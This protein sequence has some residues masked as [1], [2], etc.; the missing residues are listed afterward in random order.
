MSVLV[1]I[2]GT[3]ALVNVLIYWLPAMLWIAHHFAG[4]SYVEDIRHARFLPV[5]FFEI[6][7]YVLLVLHGIGFNWYV[8]H[9][10]C[11]YDYTTPARNRWKDNG[12][13]L[14]GY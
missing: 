12:N 11:R 2:F 14:I 9:N 13:Y 4:Y 8:S 6:Y 3:T 1:Y 5:R 7:F 10:Y